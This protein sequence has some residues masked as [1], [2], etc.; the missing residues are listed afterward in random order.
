VK[1]PATLV[2]DRVELRPIQQAD[3]SALESIR[4]QP[5]VHRW[6]GSSERAT[7][8]VGDAET[9]TRA[10]WREGQIVGFVQWH[11][12]ADPRYRYAGI[13]IFVSDTAQG[14]GYG[15]EAVTLVLRELVASGHHRVVIDPAASNERAIACYRAC[16]FETVGVMRK[17]ERDNDGGGWHDGVMME[18]VVEN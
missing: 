15:R 5:S 7:W 3:V 11:E 8:A 14:Q 4:A 16:G 10:I 18:F 2:G 17:Y 1:E 6:W 13:D 12:N 9:Q